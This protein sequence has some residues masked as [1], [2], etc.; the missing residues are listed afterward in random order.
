MNVKLA[1]RRI[2]PRILP[3]V[4]GG[5]VLANLTAIAL[6]SLIPLA[7]GNAVML[8][9]LLSFAF[10]CAAIIW[11]FAARSVA[12]AWLGIGVWIMFA[13]ALILLS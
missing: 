2:A 1:N 6:A 5:Y 11:A 3:A 8:S 12:R 9:I 7:R 10:Y 13:A 4:V